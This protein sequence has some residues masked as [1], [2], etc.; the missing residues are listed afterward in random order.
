MDAVKTPETMIK[1]RVSGPPKRHQ[2][3]PSTG[4][5]KRIPMM[6]AAV[7]LG[8]NPNPYECITDR[9]PTLE[10]AK[11]PARVDSNPQPGCL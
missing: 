8:I 4:R 6:R 2:I 9:D 11:R 1:A 10:A 7:K 3:K 5:A